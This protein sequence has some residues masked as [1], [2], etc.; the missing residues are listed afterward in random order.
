MKYDIIHDWYVLKDDKTLS[1]AMSHEKINDVSQY[2]KKQLDISYR[3]CK[4]FRHA[5][6]IG[7]N[8]G[9]MSYNMSSQFTKISAFE[10]VPEILDCLKLNIENFNLS[11][12]DIYDC[13]LSNKEELVSLNF[14]S[15]KTFSTHVNKEEVGNIKVNKLDFYNFED[16]DFIKID[17]EG[18]EPFI[19][20]GGME[21]IKKYKPVILY[22]RKGHSLR[23]NKPNTAVLDML[24]SLGYK[25]LA[26]IDK[27]NGL[28]GVI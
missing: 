24:S 7:A 23:Y 1:R 19:I 28:I 8:Y 22:E 20:E 14:E 3:F 2:Q 11:N 16:V 13:G 25:D 10:I 15:N 26:T 5:I 12:V 4:Q 27:K 17:A 18:F 6:D 9:I 21:T